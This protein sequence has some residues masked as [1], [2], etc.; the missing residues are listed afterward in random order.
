MNSISEAFPEPRTDVTP[1]LLVRAADFERHPQFY[2]AM[3]CFS[4]MAIRLYQGPGI[5]RFLVN[6]TAR[7][8]IANLCIVFDT[9]SQDDPS[10]NLTISRIQD[11]CERLGVAS[12]GRVYAFLKMMELGNYLQTKQGADRRRG[13][14]VPSPKFVDHL[15]TIVKAMLEGADIVLAKP[16]CVARYA[17]PTVR[18][19]FIQAAGLDILAGFAPWNHYDD[20]RPFTAHD[21]G[22]HIISVILQQA[23]AFDHDISGGKHVSVSLADLARRHNLSRSHL[24]QL[25]AEAERHGLIIIENRASYNIVLTPRLIA[26][27]RA[28]VALLLAY[29]AE[30]MQDRI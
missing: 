11:A 24:R 9:L 1:D 14:L 25:L 6:E 18:R 17:D 13:R 2:R 10:M 29:Y 19:R 5:A 8:L 16:I 7:T 27:Y 30:I 26:V 15:D 20:M 12:R 28:H 23:G 3:A 4:L 22:F 21:G